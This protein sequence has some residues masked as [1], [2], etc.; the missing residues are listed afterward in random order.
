M[1]HQ[2]RLVALRLETF[3]SAAGAGAIKSQL[4]VVSQ[5]PLTGGSVPPSLITTYNTATG[6]YNLYMNQKHVAWT[7]TPNFE[8]NSNTL[9][10]AMLPKS[11]LAGNEPWHKNQVPFSGCVRSVELWH[12]ELSAENVWAL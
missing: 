9:T 2:A 6:N 12:A 10:V 7:D 4:S 11:Y 1:L 3:S 8:M 5:Q